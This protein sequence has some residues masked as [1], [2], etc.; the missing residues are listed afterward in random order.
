MCEFAFFEE[1]EMPHTVALSHQGENK[2]G[3]IR[4]HLFP[5]REVPGLFAWVSAASQER[6]SGK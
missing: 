2:H 4:V 5:A 1:W 6:L 3:W